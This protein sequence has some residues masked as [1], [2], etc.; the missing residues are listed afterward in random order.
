[1]KPQLAVMGVV[2]LGAAWGAPNPEAPLSFFVAPATSDLSA[3]GAPA[4]AAEVVSLVAARG[5]R[6]SFFVVLQPQTSAQRIEVH[7]G[8]LRG[9]GGE[10]PKAQVHVYR[11]GFV[12][13]DGIRVLDPLRPMPL[14]KSVAAG[15]GVAAV[16][17]PLFFDLAVPRW[18]QPGRYEGT[19]EVRVDEA[20]AQVPI[21]LEV[22]RLDLPRQASLPTAF[23]FSGR[24]LLLGSG[25]AVSAPDGAAV[26]LRFAMAG[27]ASRVTFIEGGVEAPAFKVLPGNGELEIDFERFDLEVG[28]LLDGV[29]TLEG[30]RASALALPLPSGLTSLQRFKYVL[31]FRRHLKEKGWDDRL[32]DLVVREPEALAA[33]L[34]RPAHGQ[35]WGELV[36]RKGAWRES[37]WWSV[38]TTGSTS[39]TLGAPAHVVRAIPWLAYR[40]GAAGLRYGEVLD[41]FRRAGWD[42]SLSRAALFYP[43][44]DVLVESI[45][46]KHLRD[47]LEDYELLKLAEHAGQGALA[48]T[49]ARRL[50]ASPEAVHREPML[51]EKA[52]RDLASALSK[53]KR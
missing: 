30:A 33:S 10:L 9:P 32:V 52:K 26:R 24:E 48:Q 22:L 15:F 45:R 5:E 2:F 23:E 7:A 12:D 13:L 19:I 14:G 38:P 37:A 36:A 11:A 21:E 27:L 3:E 42:K 31:A 44:P 39:L 43:S 40:A 6:E 18:A 50:A 51:F 4:R 46:L 29:E 20:R 53:A 25:R 34:G 8:A 35:S 49:W 47:G 41:G 16:N 28:V 17:V 1:M